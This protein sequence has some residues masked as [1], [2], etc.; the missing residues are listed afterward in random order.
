MPRD[1][2]PI[3][4]V[5]SDPLA[6]DP[7][8]DVPVLTT[9]RLILRG[10]RDEDRAPYAAINADPEV[11]R[12]LS[13]RFTRE[14]TD[15][16]I[17]RMR[18]GWG[19]RG[20]G[21]WAVERSA[22]GALLGMTGL[23]FHDFE[24]PFTPCVEIGWRFARSAWGHGYATEAA[25]AALRFG[26]EALGLDEIVSFTVVD[27][28]A[29]RRVMERLGMRHDPANDFGHPMFPEGHRLRPHVLYRLS[30]DDW[31]RDHGQG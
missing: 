31:R 27:N 30:R 24:A 2:L 3:D 13:K 29:S 15:A 14:E 8:A 4:R 16:M 12:F 6:S 1:S 28:A 18:A 9:E 20:Y 11:T 26:F 21:L 25:D 17:D 7:P 23:S 22:D 5:P 10:W 19:R